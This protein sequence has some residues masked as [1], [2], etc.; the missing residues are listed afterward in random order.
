MSLIV[1]NSPLMVAILIQTSLLWVILPRC[2][3]RRQ[4]RARMAEVLVKNEFE[5]PWK[6]AFVA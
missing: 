5:G 4:Y 1:Y 6:E 3:C 2:W